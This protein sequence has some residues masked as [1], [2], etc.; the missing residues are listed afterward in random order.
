MSVFATFFTE[1]ASK[2]LFN[3][4]GE[5][6]HGTKLT[7]RPPRLQENMSGTVKNVEG[8][9]TNFLMP[10]LPNVTRESKRESLINIHRL[11]SGDMAS[12]E[13]KVGGGWH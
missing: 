9:L 12:M 4:L 8:V 3:R 13:S 1:H 7:S 10:I 6:S 5:L 11:I 2:Y